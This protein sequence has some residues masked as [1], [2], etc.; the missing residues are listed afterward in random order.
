MAPT[1]KIMAPALF[2]VYTLSCAQ[3]NLPRG[4]RGIL[5]TSVQM[6]GVQLHHSVRC[7]CTLESPCKV[8][9]TARCCTCVWQFL[10]TLVSDCTPLYT[11]VQY[12]PFA[13]HNNVLGKTYPKSGMSQLAGSVMILRGGS[14]KFGPGAGGKQIGGTFA[15]R[16]SITKG[17]SRGYMV[18]L[19]ALYQLGHLP[20]ES[21]SSV[22]IY[23]SPGAHQFRPSNIFFLRISIF[24]IFS[25][26]SISTRGSYPMSPIT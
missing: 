24:S 5:H 11:S 3:L 22:P 21:S 20:T 2:C 6:A 10:C 12:S 4:I 26:F 17:A 19:R 1:P 15:C 14:R 7:N 13:L 25:I 8:D 23:C 16:A 9:T 18:G